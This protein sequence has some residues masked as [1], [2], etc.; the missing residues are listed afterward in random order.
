MTSNES[1][2]PAV[3]STS[4]VAPMSGIKDT[5]I[6]ISLTTPANTRKRR[7]SSSSDEIL[8]SKKAKAD[9]SAGKNT[10]GKVSIK[11]LFEPWK[12]N[13][14]VPVKD[15]GWGL[16]PY[17]VKPEK[18][19]RSY[20]S[21]PPARTSNAKTIP[22]LWENRFSRFKPGQ[23]HTT[24]GPMSSS[25][26]DDE[27]EH[28]E[29][30]DQNNRLAIPLMDMRTDKTTGQPKRLPFLYFYPN[31]R[32]TEWGNRQMLKSLNDR[33]RD[34]VRR[35]TCDPPWSEMEREYL[36]R[37]CQD[38]PNA[39][40]FELAERF[41][42]RFYGD[43][44][45]K[46]ALPEADEM[47]GL[48]TLESIRAEYLDFKP[49]YDAGKVP[50]PIHE[51]T[52]KTAEG[53]AKKVLMDKVLVK[54][55]FKSIKGQDEPEK[56]SYSTKRFS[57]KKQCAVFIRDSDNAEEEIM[58]LKPALLEPNPEIHDELLDLAGWDKEDEQNDSL[59]EQVDTYVCPYS[60]GEVAHLY[61]ILAEYGFP[62]MGAPNSEQTTNTPASEDDF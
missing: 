50:T 6:G 57:R 53:K 46:T 38:H 56:P 30:N 21:L 49:L 39:S 40:I 42:Y 36:T 29:E 11:D 55:G 7:A 16:T 26:S 25:E 52:E 10:D 51:E 54:F 18:G 12:P 37:L 24:Y 33:R 34:A 17:P 60:P 1:A 44:R 15:D 35:I 22:D 4:P 41:N 9:N 59:A 62:V 43:F 19:P 5:P 13:M 28:T 31:G 45:E 23:Y 3:P 32:P 27:A 14:E 47:C 58:H 48:R 2:L 20:P 61:G 8:T